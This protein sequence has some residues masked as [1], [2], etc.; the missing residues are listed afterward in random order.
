LFSHL[1][2]HNIL[3]CNQF[4]FRRNH[5]STLALIE[6]VDNIY[7]YLDNKEIT[8]GLY[9]DL[10]KAFDTVNHQILLHKMYNYGIRGIVLDWYRN[11]L[12]NR[13]QYTVVNNTTSELMCIKCGVPQGS[14][15]GPLLFL[16]YISD[17]HKAIPD[18]QI[19]L[20]ADDTNLFIHGP[21]EKLVIQKTNSSLKLLNEWFVA[22]KLSLNLDKTCYTVFGT[23]EGCDYNIHLNGI[24]I[25][26]VPSC[27][28]IGVIIDEK[29][30]WTEHIDNIYSKLVKF[31]G[32]FYK[33]RGKIPT[34]ILKNIYF[35]FV[36]PH[37]LYG[38]ELYGN[39]CPTYLD[40]INKLNNKLLRILQ[41]KPVITPIRELFKTYNTLPI[42]LLH[43]QQILVFVYNVMY[44]SSQMPEVFRDYFIVNNMIHNYETR[45]QNKLHLHSIN[46]LYGSRSLR[47]KGCSLFNKLP[48]SLQG[49]M[50]TSQFKQELKDFLNEVV[51]FNRQFLTTTS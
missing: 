18:E 22:N 28:Y 37:L 50:P 34:K 46:S 48:L 4:G 1:Q 9:L 13:K 20:Y 2:K 42:N 29:L 26:R 16:I 33:L 12:T 25:K 11:Y 31:V 35:A 30:K 32:I 49:H 7:Q 19:K 38:I 14:V 43:M 23:K 10:Q 8:V 5:N 6:A 40:K 17:I 41:N 45:S 51:L 24:T 44:N 27:R 36:H 15:L 47:Y 39:T 3:Y 21:D